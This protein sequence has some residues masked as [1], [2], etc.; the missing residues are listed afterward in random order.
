MENETGFAVRNRSRFLFS[1]HG[2]TPTR[3]GWVR[4]RLEPSPSRRPDRR[5]YRARTRRRSSTSPRGRLPPA[6]RDPSTL[7]RSLPDHSIAGRDSS[8]HEIPHL[9]V[10]SPPCAHDPGSR[11]HH[12]SA[13]PRELHPTSTREQ[14]PSRALRARPCWRSLVG[15]WRPSTQIRA[16]SSPIPT[17]RL[18]QLGSSTTGDSQIPQRH[19]SASNIRLTHQPTHTSVRRKSWAAAQTASRNPRWQTD[20]EVRR[21]S[22]GPARQPITSVI[23]P[24]W[25]R[26]REA[27]GPRL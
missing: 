8:R 23:T 17:S 13:L 1:T 26:R 7:P 12:P 3:W 22:H 6:T 18:P 15:G 14:C 25:S 11:P 19:A 27:S 20:F 10:R 9:L 2:P 16:C 24:P 4:P 21:G 5:A